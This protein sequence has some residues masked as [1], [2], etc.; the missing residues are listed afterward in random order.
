MQ[1]TTNMI[2]FLIKHGIDINNDNLIIRLAYGS[3]IELPFNNI[4]LIQLLLN[5]GADPNTLIKWFTDP[6]NHLCWIEN[7]HEVIKLLLH[8]G[9]DINTVD[10]N[11]QTMLF[12]HRSNK[13]TVHLLIKHKINVNHQ[14]NNGDTMLHRLLLNCTKFSDISL[15]TKMVLNAGYNLTLQNKN[16]DTFEDILDAL[17]DDPYFHITKPL[18][19]TKELLSYYKDI[20][21]EPDIY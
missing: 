17:I 14:D 18:D 11:G 4:E 12:W 8:Q 10:D 9:A 1:V 6:S 21:K 20:I 5:R 7:M 19:D 16:G 15:I 2:P 3:F 13:N